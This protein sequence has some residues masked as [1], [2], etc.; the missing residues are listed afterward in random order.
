[1]K[2]TW[3]MKDGTEIAICDMTI[4][5]IQYCKSM[6]MKS[7]YYTLGIHDDWVE[8]FDKELENRNIELRQKKLE[9]L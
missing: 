5:H 8:I 7:K 9:S 1:M 3:T 2:D 4:Q 6:L